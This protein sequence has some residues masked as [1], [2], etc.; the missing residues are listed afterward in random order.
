MF[1]YKCI[2]FR[3]HKMPGLEQIISYHLQGPFHYER[4]YT[5]QT[6]T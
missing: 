6:W 5:L 4:S 3:E 2:N 1:Q